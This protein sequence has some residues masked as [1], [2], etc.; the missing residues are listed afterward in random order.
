MGAGSQP[1]PR[2][3]GEGITQHDISSIGPNPHSCFLKQHGEE[4]DL[5]WWCAHAAPLCFVQE[6]EALELQK[7]K[8]RE[9]RDDDWVAEK[10][11]IRQLKR[12]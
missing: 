4:A 9:E 7:A 1:K 2:S 6:A 11:K 5:L 10:A 8:K 3:A 12:E